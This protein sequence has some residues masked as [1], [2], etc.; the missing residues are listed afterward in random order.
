MCL[1]TSSQIMEVCLSSLKVSRHILL[2]IVELM[3][4][5]PSE[6]DSKALELHFSIFQQKFDKH[7]TKTMD[8][9]FGGP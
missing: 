5:S 6:P 2:P 7:W 1:L 3:T 8:Q 4:R 9:N